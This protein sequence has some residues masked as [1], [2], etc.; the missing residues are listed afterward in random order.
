MH[1]VTSQNIKEDENMTAN[2]RDPG[3]E[4]VSE[5]NRSFVLEAGPIKPVLTNYP[6]N[7]IVARVYIGSE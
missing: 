4:S 5:S 2:T 7:L 6:T 3:I 1:F